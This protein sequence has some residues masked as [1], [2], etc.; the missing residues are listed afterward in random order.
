MRHSQAPAA[1]TTRASDN[2]TASPVSSAQVRSA[3]GTRIAYDRIGRGEPVILVDAALCRRGVGPSRALAERLASQFTV[4]TYD[5]RGRGESGDTPPHAVEREVEDISALLRELGGS[6]CLWGMSSGAVLALE[7][8]SRLDGITKLALYEA[9]CI[10][11]DNGPATTVQW[12]GIDEALAAHRRGEA[13]ACF[14]R[15]IGVPRVFIALMR[16]S[17][18]WPKLEAMAHTLPYDGVLVHEVQRGRALPAERWRSVAVPTLV[19]AGGKSPEWMQRGNRA[20][21]AALPAARYRT[22][23]GQSHVLKPKV[24]AP[25]LAE[26]LSE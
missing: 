17:P 4:V 9:P 18:M 1:P 2:A 12:N 20:L 21:A 15:G 5:R 23:E 11:D 14:L 8:A 16:L 25:A 24:H 10:L 22:L 6:A 13:V 19:M 3:D 7:A 26:F